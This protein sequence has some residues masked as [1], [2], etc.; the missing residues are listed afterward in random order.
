MATIASASKPTA[1]ALSFRLL[2]PT[3]NKFIIVYYVAR[4]G[5]RGTR[6]H[7][8]N[9]LSPNSKE[10]FASLFRVRVFTLTLLASVPLLA[11]LSVH[12]SL[13]EH[14]VTVGVGRLMGW[15]QS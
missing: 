1:L 5:L 2:L 13:L 9:Q 15:L 6:N 10:Q 3:P 12:T 11:L 4:N 8:N 7:Q 14:T